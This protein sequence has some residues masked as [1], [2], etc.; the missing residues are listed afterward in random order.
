MS[1]A[2]ED[3]FGFTQR[4]RRDIEGL[5]HLHVESVI[6]QADRPGAMDRAVEMAGKAGERQRTQRAA[7]SLIGIRSSAP[8]TAR[9]RGAKEPE[10]QHR[11]GSFPIP[12]RDIWR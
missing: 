11:K 2:F 3:V 9:T 7:P 4:V 12:A 10:Q 8:S 1:D 6:W 5:G